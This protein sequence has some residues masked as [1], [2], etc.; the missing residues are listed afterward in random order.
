MTEHAQNRPSENKCV[1]EM[2]LREKAE[3]RCG[4][5]VRLVKRNRKFSSLVL[6]H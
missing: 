3:R 6:V 4:I 5:L 2:P 1:C